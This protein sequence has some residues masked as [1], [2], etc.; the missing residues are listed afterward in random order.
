[1]KTKIESEKEMLELGAG[2]LKTLVPGDVV[3]LQGDLG[4]GK[5]VFARGFLNAAGIAVVPSPTFTIVNK[6]DTNI[7]TVF[8]MDA[9]RIDD[10]EEARAAGLDEIIDDKTAIKFIEWPEKITEILP[11]KHT[12]INIIKTGD[13]TRE[14]MVEVRQ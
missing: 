14:L 12:L 7:G 10:I 3:L 8:H 11:K 5:S 4:S 9:Y 1:M 2:F 13:A 6:Y